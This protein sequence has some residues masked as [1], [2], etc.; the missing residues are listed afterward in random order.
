MKH[1]ASIV[2]SA[3]AL[4]VAFAVVP[5]VSSAQPAPAYS[6]PAPS[7]TPVPNTKPDFSSM[8]FLTGTWN[9]SGMVRGSKRPDTS[10]TTM[11]LDGTWMV[12]QDSAPPFDQ[13]RTYTINSTTYT[14]YDPT[15]KLWIQTGVD[16]SG[17]YFTST[18]P[19][20]Q[21]STMT[22]TTKN[23]DGSSGTDA[24]TKN[25]DTSTTDVATNTDA[26][27]HATNV[28]TTCTKSM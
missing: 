25:S 5:A 27:G 14:G 26:Q 1:L 19:G 15:T 23:L 17:A 4:A 3:I 9:C 10:T 11:G 12:T 13:Y 24:F 28:T 8:S 22:W 7:Y 20:W 21:G 2:L 16:S 6:Q 18:S